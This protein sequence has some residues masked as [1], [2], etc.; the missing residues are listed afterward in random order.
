VAPSQTLR[1]RGAFESLFASGQRAQGSLMR[2]LFIIGTDFPG[3]VEVGFAVPKRL[4]K[5]TKRN[6]VRR[7]MRESFRREEKMVTA[8]LQEVRRSAKVAFVFKSPIASAGVGR[9]ELAGVHR[10]MTKL[11]AAVLSAAR[12]LS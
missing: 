11:V 2:C 10:D 1:G 5:A 4:G 7:L 9:V 6:R 8:A 12:A 3:R